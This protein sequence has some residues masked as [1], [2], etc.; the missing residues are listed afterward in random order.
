MIALFSTVQKKVERSQ[1]EKQHGGA[2][3]KKEDVPS[4]PRLCDEPR[5]SGNDWLRLDFRWLL[6][7]RTGRCDILEFRVERERMIILATSMARLDLG[8]Q[9]AMAQTHDDLLRARLRSAQFPSLIAIA[10]DPEAIALRL[11]RRLSRGGRRQRRHL[12]IES[13]RLRRCG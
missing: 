11:G 13:R 12:G 5:P 4:V 1:A 7:R 10:Q 6:L 8:G 2:D 3:P 9:P